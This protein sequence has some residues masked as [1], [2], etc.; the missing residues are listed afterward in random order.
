MD[1]VLLQKL[2]SHRKR[3]GKTRSPGEFNVLAR[4]GQAFSGAAAI[5]PFPVEEVVVREIDGVQMPTYVTWLTTACAITLIT[6]PATVLPC[7]R[8]PA[9]TPF[10]LQ[11]AGGDRADT[12]TLAVAA[13]I[14]TAPADDDAFNHPR[15]G[16]ALSLPPSPR[17]TDWGDLTVKIKDVRVSVHRIPAALPLI[18][19]RADSVRAVCEVETDQGHVGVGM[20]AR[21]LCHGVAAVIRHHIA[22][23]VLGTDPRDLEAI[24]AKL[25]PIV[26]ERGQMT[27]IN[28]AALS[29]VD[30]AL[31][32]IIGQASERTVAGLL[33][34]HRKAVDVYVTFGFGAYDKEQ[35]VDVARGLIAKGHSRLKML[36]G[37]AANGVAGDVERVR[38][39]RNA[40]GDDVQLAVDANESVSLD[41]AAALARRIEDCNIA[42]F[43]DPVVRNDPS[44]L[45]ILRRHTSIPLSAGQMDGHSSRFRTWLEHGALDIFMPNSMYNG[46]MTETRKVAHLADIYNRPLSDA[47]GGGIYCLHHVA[48]F[49]HG[50]LA[51]WH[52]G[53]EQVERAVF[54]DPP[55]PER[56]RLR[57]PKS[58]GFGVAINKDVLRETLITA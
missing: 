32:D 23:A 54:V 31:W 41:Y 37:V 38:H 47:G 9:S 53:V 27:G 8:G 43:E 16:P 57:V 24:H 42:W 46:G 20:A 30:L 50:T 14:E 35:L 25:K 28:L 49:H 33:G 45:A 3:H 58:P 56:G 15:P 55:V 13:A 40:I 36:V 21:F 52:L 1:A 39:V 29:C 26:S 44:D 2:I 22:P 7:G 19:R 10:G 18:D 51:E 6:H 11:I 17:P 34:G 4:T 5:T 48:G 12:D